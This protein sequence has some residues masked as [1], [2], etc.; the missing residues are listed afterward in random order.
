MRVNVFV[1]VSEGE[2]AELPLETLAAGVVFA[3]I[4][5]AVASPVAEGLDE[6]P[7]WAS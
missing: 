7:S 6:N 2:I 5:P 4:A 3:G 1:V